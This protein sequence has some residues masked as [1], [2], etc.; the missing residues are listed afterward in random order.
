MPLIEENQLNLIALQEMFE[1]NELPTELN[2][3]DGFVKVLYS[4]EF[5][6]IVWIKKPVIR[7]RIKILDRKE[8]KKLEDASKLNESE[9]FLSSPIIGKFDMEN[10]L[11]ITLE[12]SLPSKYGISSETIIHAGEM[13]SLV[14]ESA[15]ETIKMTLDSLDSECEE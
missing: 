15:F 9:L 12:Y 7:M 13:L 14:A 2:I 11:G 6:L 3:I 1:S 4:N 8:S 5:D 10:L